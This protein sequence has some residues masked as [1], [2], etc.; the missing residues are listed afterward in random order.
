MFRNLLP[1]AWQSLVVGSFPISMV[2][3]QN[4]ILEKAMEIGN[5]AEK[6]REALLVQTIV[7]NSAKGRGAVVGLQKTLDAIREGRVQTLVFCDGYR[8]PGKRCTSC[9]YVTVTPV[10]ICP[11]CGAKM[12]EIE[13][14]VELAVQNVMRADGEV[15]V[16]NPDQLL[17]GFGKIGAIL[18]Y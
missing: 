15:E 9:K 10:E 8:D 11:Y 14:A 2:A 18:R 5:Q 1:K 6:R 13:D 17:D 4:E 16:L 12:E 7:T 3:S